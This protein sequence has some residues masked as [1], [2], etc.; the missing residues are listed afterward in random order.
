MLKNMKL[1]TKIGVGFGVLIAIAMMLG[2]L[3]VYNMKSVAV[4]STKLADEYVP[5]VSV[6]VEIRGAANRLM[7]AMRGYGFTEEDLFY[8]E[9]LKEI[10]ALEK[11]IEKGEQ[12]E[13]AALSLEKLK[14]QLATVASYKSEY[15]AA[16]KETQAIVQ[17]LNVARKAL[18]SNAAVYMRT[19]GEFLEGQNKALK[20]DLAKRQ[21]KIQLVSHLVEIGSEVRVQ[22]FKAQASGDP[23][24]LQTAIERLND[25]FPLITSL[26]Q[27]TSH[28][29]DLRRMDVI[30]SATK[31][32]QAAMGSFL[33]EFKKGFSADQNVLQEARTQMDKNA[34]RYVSVCETYLDTQQAKLTSDITE[35]HAKITYANDIIDLG[36]DTRIKAYKSQALRDPELMMAGERNFGNIFEALDKLRTITRLPVD[37]KRIDMVEGAARGYQQVMKAFLE[38]WKRLQALGEQRTAIGNQTIQACVALA[39][40]GMEY[41]ERIAVGAKNDLNR[42]SNIMIGGLVV[43]LV[44][45]I[46]LAVLITLGITRPIRKVIEGLTQGSQ[47]VAAAS[48]EVS[49][50][51]QSLAEG[52]SQQA[53]SI[54]E[55]SSSLEEMSA[56]TKQ[57]S[58]NASQADLLMKEA[59]Q[60]VS[61]ANSSMSELTRSMEDIS[62]ASEETSKIIK[63]IDEIAFQTNLLALNAAVE[64]A[65]A[66][67]AGAGFAV[68]A[69]EV[70]NLAMRSAEAAKNTALLIE[71]TVTK[72]QDGSELVNRTSTA[73]GQV[74]NSTAKVGE[75]V[76]EIAAAS[77][78][79]ATGIAQINLAV[80]E[81]DKVTQQN[82]ANAEESA[83]ASEE[84]NAQA[85]T[86]DDFVRDLV[87]VVEGAS[88]Q[89]ESRSQRRLPSRAIAHPTMARPKSLVSPGN[90]G[91]AAKGL[92][93]KG[94]VR[95]DQVIPFDDDDDDFSD[96]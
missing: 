29:E 8:G 91:G 7:Y 20:T 74:A 63:T 72:V 60:V 73:F 56:M 93:R 61:Q 42:S 62:K 37:L 40:A 66:G 14:E 50:A 3:A 38:D 84:M 31:G 2:G 33:G 4:E 69:E 28:D 77:G 24:M 30:E 87:A 36:N 35:G 82:A 32:Y 70:R 26:R 13:K 52:A 95:P 64:A 18:D 9:A 48:G 10:D 21:K 44:L 65:R 76:G 85:E 68:V 75:L 46:F 86:M 92:P 59:N 94:E 78:E 47:Q 67:E 89:R 96:F 80:A 6:A 25:V 11:G 53:A 55:S 45:G 83:S 5:E 81:M 79:Q 15:L 43:A 34:G 51:S 19:S 88:G 1:G 12:L 49:S 57:N 23:A 39:D 41:T 71:D 22:N 17:D 90:Q 27:M 16:M 54:E 58:Q